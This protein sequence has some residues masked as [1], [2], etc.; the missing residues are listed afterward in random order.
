MKKYYDAIGIIGLVLAFYGYFSAIF[1]ANVKWF[2][3]FIVGG[4]FF[5]GYINLRLKNESIFKKSR[6]YI[7][8]TYALY[9]LF[10]ILIDIVGGYV[11]GLWGYP[12]FGLVDKIINVS[13]IGYPFVCFFIQESFNLLH[14]ILSSYLLTIILTTLINAF[15]VELPNISA[16]EWVYNIPYITFSILQINIVVIVGWIILIA[17]PFISKRIL[18]HAIT[19][20]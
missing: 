5:L 15:L 17:V 7:L 14:K 18:K 4:T 9:L 19:A 11:L 2:S 6:N 12:S 8:K 13:L 3:Y 1:S 20:L 16:Q 10:G